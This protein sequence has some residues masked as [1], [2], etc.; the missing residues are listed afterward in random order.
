MSNA[1]GISVTVATGFWIGPVAGG[2]RKGNHALLF[3]ELT[4]CKQASRFGEKNQ[5]RRKP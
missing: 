3:R 5:L 1:W 2:S 4:G